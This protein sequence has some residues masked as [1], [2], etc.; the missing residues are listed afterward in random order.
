VKGHAPKI[1][2]LKRSHCART[3]YLSGAISVKGHA[4]KILKLKRSHC[5]RTDYLSGRYLR[6]RP[7]TQIEPCHCAGKK[8]NPIAIVLGLLR[9]CHCAILK[10]LQIQTAKDNTDQRQY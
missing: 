2:K 5:A 6:E 10:E 3:D 4:L 7:R 1:L 8:S 9:L